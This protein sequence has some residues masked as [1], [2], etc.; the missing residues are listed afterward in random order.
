MVIAVDARLVESLERRDDKTFTSEI[1]F[2]IAQRY[3]ADRF[4]LV[5]TEELQ[6][7]IFP[8]N[9]STVIIPKKPSTFLGYKWWY[10]VKLPLILKKHKADVFIGTYGLVSLTSSIPQV[11]VVNDLSFLHK[12]VSK[13]TNFFRKYH[14]PKFLKKAKSVCTVSN[15]IKQEILL[16]YKT[17]EDKIEVIGYGESSLYKVLDWEERETIKEK[18]AKSCEY[19]IYSEGPQFSSNL[20]NILKAFSIFKKW[21]K[22]NMKLVVLAGHQDQFEPYQERLKAYKYKDELFVLDNLNDKESATVVGAAYAS[23]YLPA[24]DGA[25]V[26]V[27]NSINAGV[28]VITAPHT[29]MEEIAG[30]A[31]LYASPSGS[32]EFAEQMKIMFKD[33]ELRTRLISHG[34]ERVKNYSWDKTAMLLMQSIEKA[35]SK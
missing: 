15:F 16:K 28:P 8:A 20:L 13:S 11:M 18:Y 9:V 35:V 19:F 22:T 34:K 23:I 2:A 25:G 17:S 31:A 5:V 6:T 14:T 12:N 33:E 21:Q 29:A 10:D 26:P 4:I 3:S 24:Y 30:E 7:S 1:V 27:L 32:E